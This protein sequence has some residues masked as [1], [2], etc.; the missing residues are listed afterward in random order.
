MISFE[1]PM[2]DGPAADLSGG[3]FLLWDRGPGAPSLQDALLA[4]IIRQRLESLPAYGV[5]DTVRFELHGNTVILSGLAA[6]RE[7]PQDAMQAVSGLPIVEKV[8]N[9][10][11]LL[12]DGIE[13]DLIRAEAY[14]RL[15]A[16]PVLATYRTAGA[17]AR[18]LPAAQ[19]AA[20][21]IGY[22]FHG[23]RIVVKR[24]ELTL[25]GQVASRADA[26]RACRLAHT[27]HG[28]VRV[29]CQL[30]VSGNWN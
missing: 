26:E 8:I 12:P 14:S 28:V 29:D 30:T 5:F 22:G 16:D 20:A 19:R 7:L 18:L 21:G 3:L 9:L 24:G 25:I 2:Y 17:P 10:I 1:R 4:N 15:Y 23:I 13:D 6:N 27:I 11:E